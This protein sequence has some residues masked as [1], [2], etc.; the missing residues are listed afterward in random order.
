M[1]K[2]NFVCVG[3]LK[4]VY[5]RDAVNEYL[6]RLSRFCRA[7]VKELSEKNSLKEESEDILRACKG[8]VFALAIEGKGCSSE[9]FAAKIRTLV[10]RGEEITFVI[11]SS[12]GLD[13]SVKESA[14]ELISFSEMTFPHQLMRVILL[15]QVYRAFM[16][17][18]GSEYHK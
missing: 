16:I 8:Y 6:K 10:D 4:E 17:N 18:S 5:L 15:E 13:G 9:K 7:E 1:V 2:V 12:C 3:K 14:N 11:G